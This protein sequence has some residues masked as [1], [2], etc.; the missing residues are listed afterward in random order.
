MADEEFRQKLLGRIN[1]AVGRA[2]EAEDRQLLTALHGVIATTGA[3]SLER[4]KL[5]LAQAEG[6]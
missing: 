5:F 3:Y 6:V 1:D 4:F 2:D